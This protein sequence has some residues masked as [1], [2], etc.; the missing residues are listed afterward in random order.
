MT[1]NSR[2]PLTLVVALVLAL[3]STAALSAPAVAAA[4]FEVC[5]EDAAALDPG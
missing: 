3:V 4:P 2:R 1:R 5:N